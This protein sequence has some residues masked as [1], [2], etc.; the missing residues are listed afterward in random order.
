MCNTQG[1]TGAKK[2][3]ISK[4]GEDINKNNMDN[5]L[6]EQKNFTPTLEHHAIIYTNISGVY[7]NPNAT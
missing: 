7:L 5:I 1:Q 6:N 3:G 2:V 4:I